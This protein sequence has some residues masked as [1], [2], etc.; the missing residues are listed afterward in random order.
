[1]SVRPG[2]LSAVALLRAEAVAAAD[3]ELLRRVAHASIQVRKEA[4]LLVHPA[5]GR[6]QHSRRVLREWFIDVYDKSMAA[7]F[8]A[9]ESSMPGPESVEETT[10]VVAGSVRSDLPRRA[11]LAATAVLYHEAQAQ[12]WQAAATIYDQVLE[13]ADR[14]AIAAVPFRQESVATQILRHWYRRCYLDQL[15]HAVGLQPE[16]RRVS[17]A[18]AEHVATCVASGRVVR[19]IGTD[20]VPLITAHGTT[21]TA[22]DRGLADGRTGLQPATLG[23]LERKSADISEKSLR[24]RVRTAWA[25]TSVRERRRWAERVDVHPDEAAEDWTKLPGVVQSAW[26][27]SWLRSHASEPAPFTGAEPLAGPPEETAAAMFNHVGWLIDPLSA[28]DRRAV[29]ATFPQAPGRGL[30]RSAAGRDPAPGRRGRDDGQ[31]R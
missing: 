12:A 25:A 29:E 31:E 11:S 9:P 5:A 23:G 22:V 27:R 4:R 1:M 10:R 30:D 2:P 6:Y 26:T 20:G 14:M 21:M 8:G 19:I 13:A 18:E 24:V 3:A 17:D 16:L 28:E 7:A 15:D